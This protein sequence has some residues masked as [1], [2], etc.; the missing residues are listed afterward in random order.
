[1]SRWLRPHSARRGGSRSCSLAGRPSP[2]LQSLRRPKYAGRCA[3]LG[4]VH[5]RRGAA[6]PTAPLP[7]RVTGAFAALSAPALGGL[8]RRP[9]TSAVLP[10][11]TGRTPV[12]PPNVD[13]RYKPSLCLTDVLRTVMLRGLQ[14]RPR[15]P[16][17]DEVRQSF[18]RLRQAKAPP[19]FIARSRRINL[20]TSFFFQLKRKSEGETLALGRC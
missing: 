14:S 4:C 19:D 1:M 20:R 11:G 10:C 2:R 5:L 9:A 18:V 6:P 12:L 8:P 13:R 3:P 17:S 7:L 16:A 15:A